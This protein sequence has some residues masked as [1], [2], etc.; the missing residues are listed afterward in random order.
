MFPRLT[1]HVAKQQLQT[2]SQRFYTPMIKF[3]GGDRTAIERAMSARQQRQPWMV[4]H[5][6]TPA[7]A[8]AAPRTGA[9]ENTARHEGKALK[10]GPL[11]TRVTH[12]ESTWY[13]N[14][15]NKNPAVPQQFDDKT[16]DLI[17][18]GGAL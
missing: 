13:G 8:A 10:H 7:A 6:A 14:P 16:I 5:S 12:M 1:Q 9:V 4:D 18:M 3:T 2:T 15:F 17:N 11:T